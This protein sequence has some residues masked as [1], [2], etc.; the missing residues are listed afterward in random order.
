VAKQLLRRRIRLRLRR[1]RLTLRGSAPLPWRS[2]WLR[3]RLQGKNKINVKR[4]L[5]PLLLAL[6]MAGTSCVTHSVVVKPTPCVV[7]PWPPPPT[8][9]FLP[10]CPGVCLT[11]ASAIALGMWIRNAIEYYNAA[12]TCPYLKVS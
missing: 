4:L 10:D 8:L 1:L 3:K 7:P 11:E 12:S 5:L 9:E 2:D 6:T